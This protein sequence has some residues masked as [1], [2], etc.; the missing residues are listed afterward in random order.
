LSDRR[1][2]LVAGA[3]AA[4]LF[5]MLCA[6][7]WRFTMDDTYISLRYAKHIGD[8]I[9]PVWNAVDVHDPV[10]GFTGFLHVWLL[11]A[12][13]F[14][15]GWEL[16]TPAKVLG[17]LAALTLL[18]LVAA[19][20]A[21]LGVSRLGTAVALTPFAI[22]FVALHSVSGM[23]TGLYL[24]FHTGC[25]LACL[26]ALGGPTPGAVRLFVVLGLLGTLTRPEFG[27]SFLALCAWLGLSRPRA[28]RELLGALLAIYVLPGLLLT[29]FRYA[30]YGD[31]V[32]QPFHKKQSSGLTRYGVL[33]VGRF[34][35]VV[36]LPYLLFALTGWR[37]LWKEHRD[38][39]I[40][41]GICL[42]VPSAYFVTTLPLMGWWYRFLLA[43]LPLLALLAAATTGGADQTRRPG[44]LLPVRATLLGSILLLGAATAP[45]IEHY[46]KFHTGD[47]AR[48][49]ELA[50]R[51]GDFRA[52]DRWLAYYDV[53]QLPYESEWN[54]RDVFGLNTRKAQ[55]GPYCKMKTDLI[56][57]ALTSRPAEPRQQIDNPCAE[58]Y[59]PIA[60][61]PLYREPPELDRYMRVFARRDIDYAEDLA[62]HLLR[63]W[64]EPYSRAA[65][66][67]TDYQDRLRGWFGK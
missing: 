51:L 22:P 41:T 52:D 66:G 14:V 38:L 6:W 34:L 30:Y 63:G 46:L 39:L 65:D 60:D 12:V 13:R 61:L 36:A 23:E 45:T 59:D 17:V 31:I 21:C 43:Q 24:L 50:R 8:G 35:L 29:G 9:G 53:G 42:A 67:L 7:A 1:F 19:C 16:V 27:A 44:W 54:V 5:L 47:R 4:A 55:R 37:S 20:C 62:A 25:A 26:R 15:T 64:P 49:G 11:G 32:P 48:I 40:V 2:R 33:Y 57:L 18:G 28:R 10:E 58:L 56:L 3:L